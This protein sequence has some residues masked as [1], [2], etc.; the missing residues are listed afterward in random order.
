M[1]HVKDEGASSVT[2]AIAGK[3]ERPGPEGAGP[4]PF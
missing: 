2:K 4:R 3:N 1:R